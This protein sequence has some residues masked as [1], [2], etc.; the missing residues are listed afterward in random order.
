MFAC[1]RKY[2]QFDYKL[3]AEYCMMGINNDEIHVAW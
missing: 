2:A 1:N 3:I